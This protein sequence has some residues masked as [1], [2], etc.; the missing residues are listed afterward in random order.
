[1]IR[2]F[3]SPMVD[4]WDCEIG[5]AV[6][7]S[8]GSEKNGRGGVENSRARVLRDFYMWVLECFGLGLEI[9]GC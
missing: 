7:S 1:M 8:A 3:S 6:V 4:S 2:V 9:L 5:F